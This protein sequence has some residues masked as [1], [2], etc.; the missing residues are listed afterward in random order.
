MNNKLHP[1]KITE[2]V[3]KGIKFN[4]CWI[5]EGK[6]R[7]GCDKESQHL[8]KHDVEL[9]QG[10]WLGQTQVTQELWVALTNHNPSDFRGRKLPVESVSWTQAVQ[11][12]RQLNEKLAVEGWEF[13][14][15]SEAQW[16]YAA[17]ADTEYDEYPFV[18]CEVG[19]HK[20]NSCDNTH[21]VALL[22]KNDWN[23]Y[24]MLGNVWEWCSDWY[25]DLEEDSVVDPPGPQQGFGK[26]V[27]GGSWQSYG[28]H[29]SY[30]SRSSEEPDFSGR[31]IG[32][33]LAMCRIDHAAQPPQQ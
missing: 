33:R 5:P 8:F 15:P 6:F 18:L 30:C 3:V 28:D 2:Y 11:F 20:K 21:P 24:D 9:T 29:V 27:R 14:L 25:N 10:F 17:R 13:C 26:V 1:G 16:E 12:C 22:E 19:W 23:L 32:F 31:N 7:M 4:M